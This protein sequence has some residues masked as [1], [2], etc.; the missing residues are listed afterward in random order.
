[1]NT[2][3]LYVALAIGGSPDVA[4]AKAGSLPEGTLLFMTNASSVVELTTRGQIGHA[5]I[6]MHDA[7][8][9]WVYE[10]CPGK[11]R[12]VP[13]DEYFVELARINKRRDDEDRVQVFALSAK[14]PYASEDGARM[15]TYLETQV[16]RRYSI[17]NYVRGKPYD[18]IHCAELA[19]SA[20]NQSGRYAFQDCHEIHPQALYTAL[21]PTHEPQE[22]AVPPLAVK[23]SWCVRAQRR[24][25]GWMTWCGWSWG[26]AWRFCW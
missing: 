13:V 20:L 14:K 6:V 15:R 5:A 23:E 12:R 16:G 25:A 19:A 10:A 4:A 24:C 1:M 3:W 17:K 21:L 18:G 22:I 9:A 2:I 11:V 8:A 7:G 26:E